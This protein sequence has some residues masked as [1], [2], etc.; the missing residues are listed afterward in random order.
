[1]VNRFAPF[2]AV[3]ALLCAS[4]W[5]ANKSSVAEDK[6]GVITVNQQQVGQDAFSF[7]LNEQLARGAVDNQQLRQVVR[8]ELIVQ[9]VLSQQAL[10]QKLDQSEPGK[11]LLETSKRIALAQ[12][13]QREWLQKNQVTKQALEEEYKNF[14]N[15][16]GPDEFQLRHVLLKDETAARLV[17]EKIKAGAS[18]ATMAQEYSSDEFSKSKGGLLD[19]TSPAL[20]VPG[21]GTAIKEQ[22]GSKMFET[23][24]QSQV[25][26][27]VVRIEA[28]RPIVVP[29]LETMQPHLA[30]VI[31]QRELTRAIQALVN[32]AKID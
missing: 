11:T 2:L 15:R 27:H 30:R 20:M 3:T 10:A 9:T 29:S 8:N 21:L 22:V 26:W 24:I 12:L 32:Q 25:G 17:L 1:M 19:W 31:T 4:S 23:P 28:K 14:V 6:P 18:L 5:A 7:M 16:L 13:W